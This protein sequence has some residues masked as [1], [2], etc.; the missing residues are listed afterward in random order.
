MNGISHLT[1][2]LFSFGMICSNNGYIANAR[3]IIIRRNDTLN[4]PYL[5]K[6][7]RVLH[8]IERILIDGTRWEFY[9]HTMP[10]VRRESVSQEDVRLHTEWRLKL[11]AAFHAVFNGTHNVAFY[12]NSRIRTT[13]SLSLCHRILVT[14]GTCVNDLYRIRDDKQRI[15]RLLPSFLFVRDK[16]REAGREER[17]SEKAKQF[18]K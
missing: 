2:R 16:G 4:T 17:H 10:P 12:P 9:G 6:S 7:I 15:A 1:L 8:Q 18:P 13:N 5:M 14:C 3:H 11:T